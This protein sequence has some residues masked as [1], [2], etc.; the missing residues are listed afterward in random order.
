MKMKFWKSC[1]LLLAGT[2]ITA[3]TNGDEPI[4]DPRPH[5]AAEA[6]TYVA[7]AIQYDGRLATGPQTRVDDSEYNPQGT[8]EG[9]RDELLN[10][11]DLYLTAPDGTFLESRRFNASNDLTASIDENGNQV[12]RPRTPFQ[13][14]AGDKVATVVI[15][16]PMPLMDAAPSDDYRFTTNASLPM[17][18]LAEY[19]D[20]D[21]QTLLRV[22]ASGKSEVT[23]ILEGV[24]SD[25]VIAG[26]NHIDVEVIRIASK[27]LVTKS[28]GLENNPELGGTFTDITYSVA[29]GT[30]SV[31]LFPQDDGTTYT[32]WGSDY[33][34][35]GTYLATAGEYYCY[36]DLLT[37]SNVM[38]DLR[39][40]ADQDANLAQY[41]CKLL[42]ENTHTYGEDASTT[43]YRKGNTAYILIRATFVPDAATI[44][45]GGALAAD[46][47]FYVGGTDGLIY[48]SIQAATTEGVGT[49]NQPVATYTGGKM[50]YFVWPN[51]D[52]IQ[53]PMN[54][55]VIRN[56]IYCVN[57]STINKLGVNWNPLNPGVNNPDPKPSGDE[58]ENPIDPTD[59]LSLDDTYMTVDITTR[60]WNVHSYDVDL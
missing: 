37:P 51:P 25:E 33:V 38:E 34:P 52:D 10:T 19:V 36:D 50:L 21:G 1:A 35:T 39:T 6:N 24:T 45:D 31:Y 30:L 60:P 4:T 41:P 22:A 29:Q 3:C 48:S 2:L 57:I 7:F 20:V 55:P 32:T 15:N 49:F 5:P 11:I 42:L 18:S 46:G 59:P 16:S 53:R 47:T 54:S 43:T 27:V 14:T 44:A 23:T 40:G 8:Y 17:S 26:Q 28:A 12:I 56:N 9:E 13:T 58:P